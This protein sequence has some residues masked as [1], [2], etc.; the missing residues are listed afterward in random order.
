VVSDSTVTMQFFGSTGVEF[1]KPLLGR[2]CQYVPAVNVLLVSTL[3]SV[4]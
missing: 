2:M 4:I 3:G 1:I